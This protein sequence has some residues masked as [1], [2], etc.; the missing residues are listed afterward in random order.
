[1]SR[2]ACCF[3][4]GRDHREGCVLLASIRDRGDLHLRSEAPGGA[5]PNLNRPN[6]VDRA[7]M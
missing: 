2:T 5:V 4:S 1:M 6:R 7:P 3:P